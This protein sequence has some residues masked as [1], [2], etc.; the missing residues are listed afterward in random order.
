MPRNL[1]APALAGHQQYGWYQRA[2]VP[3]PNPENKVH[4]ISQ[5]LKEGVN[6]IEERL[7]NLLGERK[8]MEAKIFELKKQ[9]VSG[10]ASAQDEMEEVNGVKFVAKKLSDIQAKELKA[11]I[12]DMKDKYKD[13]VVIA[14]FA[15]NEGY[16]DEVDNKKGILYLDSGNYLEIK[17]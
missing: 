5:L 8:D 17:K 14:L 6:D 16:L 9:L 15:A 4:N 3:Q 11:I 12:D 13:N 10:G 2:G 1:A 7:A